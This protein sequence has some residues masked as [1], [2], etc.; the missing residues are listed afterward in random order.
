LPELEDIRAQ[1]QSF[2]IIAGETTQ[3]VNLTG[4]RQPERVRG[5]FVTANFFEVFKIAPMVGRAFGPD[6]DKPG[7]ER[8]VIV[9]ESFWR[10]RMNGDPKLANQTLILN[11]EP[12][13]VIGVVPDTF[14]SPQDPAAEVWITAR[15]YSASTGNRD[16]RFLFGF[17]YLKPGVTLA[18]AQA[19]V[20]VISE[21]LARAWPKENAGRVARVELLREFSVRGIRSEMLMLQAAV[22]LILLIACAN[23]ANLMLSR[24][25][26]RLK[27]MTVRAA[28]GA[29]R[30]R[31]MRQMLT[32][33][34]LISLAGGGLGLLVAV[35]SVDPL[36]SL[37]PGIIPFG[38]AS[39]DQRVMI[40]T[41]AVAVL[42][43]V[44]SGLAPALKH[45]APDLAR[46]LKEGGRASGENAGW[47]WARSA[48]VIVQIALSLTLLAGAGLLVR[49]F[50]KLLQVEMGFN[51]ENL[52]T[53]EYRLPRGKYNSSEAQW[54]FH[55]QVVERVSAVPGVQSVALAR[56]APFSFNGGF[57]G[58]ALPD[59]EQPPQ[60]KEPRAQFNTVT[61]GYLA[62][63]NIPLLRGRMFN[64]GDRGD[65]PLVYL[66]NRTMAERFWPNED[67]IGKTVNIVE[68]G[69]PGTIVGVV[70]DT[71]QR[72]LSDPQQPQMY[73]CYNQM[74]GLFATVIARTS[75][76]PL[77]LTN[78][79]REAIWKIDPDQPLWA[80][81]TVGFLF[82]R[83]TGDRRFV[84]ALMGTFAALALALSTIGLYGVMS[85]A[86]AQR[87]RE[88]GIRMALGAQTGDIMKVVLK[89][90]MA[91]GM[92]GLGV[93]LVMAFVLTKL[94][95]TMLFEVKATDPMTFAGVA[96][97]LMSVA[98]LACYIPA[99]R[100]TK[101]DPM[102]ALRSE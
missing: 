57:A 10:R 29:G 14:R 77:S 30:W 46:T 24:G 32:E 52:L 91:L 40:F 75:V 15:H 79:A 86:V 2:E 84:L 42:T 22:G 83:T 93:G 90:G 97:L 1:A 12:F 71:K 20:D 33:S 45:G 102:I 70:G 27:E 101:V 85:Y 94:M 41:L 99:R 17:G 49:S 89:Q 80:I 95:I 38:S 96:L 43:G 19:E 81:R 11:A 78:A 59:R 100:A 87:T 69:S 56:A 26:A 18:Q 35:W 50:Y 5:G 92:I 6:E 4:G 8:V 51:P 58:I 37:S 66:I 55:R 82:E 53:F 74:P 23:L 9:R 44:L 98:L 88:I 31:L 28:L 63:L 61:T 62:T 64:E 54:D 39:L 36:L 76:E 68:G 13:S 16:F 3:S 21:R 72:F 25:A 67:P 34:L 73:S 48:F 65:T 47:R 7:A 60:G